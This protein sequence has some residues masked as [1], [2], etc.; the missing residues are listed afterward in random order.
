MLKKNNAK[1]YDGSGVIPQASPLMVE[2]QATF[3]CQVTIDN[4]PTGYPMTARKILALDADGVV[5][6]YNAQACSMWEKAFG[7]QVQPRDHPTGHHFPQRFHTERLAIPEDYLHF[8]KVFAANDGWRTMR[9]LPHALEGCR[10]L[11][12]AGYDIHIVTAMPLEY[13]HQ[14]VENLAN[15]GFPIAKVHATGR[16][17]GWNN[18]KKEILLQLKPVAFLDDLLDNFREV[19]HLLHCGLLDWHGLTNET[20]LQASTHQN[21]MQFAQYCIE[22]GNQ[23]H[24]RPDIEV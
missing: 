18:P 5:L 4:H 15:L 6:D 16:G 11:D 17:D 13:Q 3:V 23:L 12:R 24:W 9:A 22:H 19:N 10:L 7:S 1:V 14:R 8:Q 20:S 2:G 21:V